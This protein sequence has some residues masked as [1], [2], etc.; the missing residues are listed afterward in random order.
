MKVDKANVPEEFHQFI[1]L[2]ETYGTLEEP[3]IRQ[4]VDQMPREQLEAIYALITPEALDRISKWIQLR[5]DH[6]QY[7]VEQLLFAS[8]SIL[9]DYVAQRVGG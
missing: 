7:A 3:V 1:P 6:K 8:L 4:L 2:V 5:L 9:I